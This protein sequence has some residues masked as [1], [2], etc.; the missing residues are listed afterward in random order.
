[1]VILYYFTY[2]DDALSITN[3]VSFVCYEGVVI[4]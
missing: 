3:D 4:A 1:L 2:I